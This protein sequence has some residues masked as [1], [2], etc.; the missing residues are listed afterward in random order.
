MQF[1]YEVY[2]SHYIKYFE[3][4]ATNRTSRARS[5]VTSA[6]LNPHRYYTGYAILYLF[7]RK[8]RYFICVSTLDHIFHSRCSNVTRSKWL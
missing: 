4:N 5:Y 8:T 7:S 6:P 3:S 1:G 2:I